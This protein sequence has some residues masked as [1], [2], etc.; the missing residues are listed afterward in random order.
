MCLKPGSGPP[1]FH[2]ATSV[3]KGRVSFG[4]LQL[5]TFNSDAPPRFLSHIPEP[6]SCCP[7]LVYSP[8]RRAAAVP[9]FYNETISTNVGERRAG[10]F[11]PRL[12]PRGIK[13]T[14]ITGTRNLVLNYV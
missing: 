13:G 11:S 2:P 7:Q 5:L 6:P 1:P 9:A 14:R 4:I 10:S 12:F 8:S 3:S